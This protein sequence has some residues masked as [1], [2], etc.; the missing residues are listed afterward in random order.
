MHS[1][2]FPDIFLSYS[3]CFLFRSFPLCLLAVDLYQLQQQFY[4]LIHSLGSDMLI[5]TVAGISAGSQV[6]AWQ[7]HITEARSVGSSPDRKYLRLDA[8]S[9]CGLLRVLDQMEARLAPW[10]SLCRSTARSAPA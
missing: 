6:R 2:L 3:F 4:G 1:F 7:A 5:G 9:S 10:R 8:G